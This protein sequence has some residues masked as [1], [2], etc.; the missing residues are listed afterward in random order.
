MRCLLSHKW[1][2]AKLLRFESAVP[3]ARPS[4]YY[5]S[6]DRCGAVQR[7]VYDILS[8]GISWETLREHDRS[9][10]EQIQIIRQRSSRL[11]QLAHSLN[12]RRSRQGDEV[13]APNRSTVA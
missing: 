5:R 4:L 13:E 9:R 3:H 6:C 11:E 7:G 10:L 1:S 8:G 12:L 2:M